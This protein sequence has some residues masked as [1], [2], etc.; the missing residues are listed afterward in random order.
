MTDYVRS[1]NFTAKDSLPAG[2]PLKVI[3]GSDVD[4]E[5]DVV[6]IAVATKVDESGGTLTAGTIAG[7]TTLS[8]TITGSGTID[9]GSY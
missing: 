7:A 8:G 2:N 4:A 3:K 9:G 6:A 5:F 1:A